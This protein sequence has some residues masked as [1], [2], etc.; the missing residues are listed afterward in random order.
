[1]E[2]KVGSKVQ[3]VDELGR[4]ENGIIEAKDLEA[5]EAT[6][7]FIGWDSDCDVTNT[8]SK[9]RKPVDISQ[10]KSV[11]KLFFLPGLLDIL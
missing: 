6:A 4:W 9:I 5:N 2:F 1:M 8:L 7:A 3:A 10:V 11:S